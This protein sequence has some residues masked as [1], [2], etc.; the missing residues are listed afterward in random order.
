MNARRQRLVLHGSLLTIVSLVNGCYTN[1]AVRPS[2]IPKL[3]G[4]FQTSQPAGRNAILVTSSVSHV[5][6]PD[7]KTVE[8]KGTYDLILTTKD[9]KIIQFDHP[10]MI[11]K[12]EDSFLLRGANRG[13]THVAM[14]DIEATEV[15]QFS[16]TKTML[17]AAPVAL[18]GGLLM[19]LLIVRASK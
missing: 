15:R 19:G 11:D 17:V 14:T 2:E 4:A 16:Q 6:A 9:G 12:E 10:V 13:E 7:G 8:V 1:T 3:N 18:V 5:E